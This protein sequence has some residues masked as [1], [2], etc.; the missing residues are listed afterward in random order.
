[1]VYNGTTWQ[2]YTTVGQIG[3]T[4]SQGIQ[5]IQGSIPVN[6][7]LTTGDQSIGGIKTF[8]SDVQSTGF[9]I[10]ADTLNRFQQGALVLRGASPTVYFRDTVENSA[11]IHCNSNLLYVLRGGVDTETWTQVSGQWPLTINLSNNNAT[12]GGS[13]SAIGEITAYASDNRLKENIQTIENSVDKVKKLNGV[14]YDWK[15]VINDLGFHP[16]NLKNDIGLL[17]QDVLEVIPQAV[18]PAPFD[19]I[20]DDTSQTYKSKTGN[21]YLTVVY[22][23]IVP[24][25]IEAIKEQ[26]NQ[27]DKLEQDIAYLKNK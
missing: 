6:A 25:L 27:I 5:G 8:T 13:F 10:T 24:L 21:E 16:R 1:M 2:V 9:D 4:G 3:F 18:A 26:Q 12:V 7:V 11:M 17:A 22:E 19:I 14:T 15:T 23:K 20:W